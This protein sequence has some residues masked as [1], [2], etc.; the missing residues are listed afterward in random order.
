MEMVEAVALF[1]YSGRTNKELSFKKDQSIFIYK[2]MNHEWWL[3]HIAG[4]SQSGFIPDGYIKLKS[5]RRDSAPVQ[6][7]PQRSIVPN[8]PSSVTFRTLS[9]DRSNASISATSASHIVHRQSSDFSLVDEHRLE[10]AKETEILEVEL[11]INNNEEE[12]EEESSLLIES[13]ANPPVPV[14]RTIYDALSPNNLPKPSIPI[15]SSP[16][17]SVNDQQIIDIDTALR[18]ILSGIQTVEECHAQC[19][20]SMPLSNVQPET[21]APDLVINLPKSNGILTA[22]P[23]KSFDEHSLPISHSTIIIDLAHSSRSNS[24]SPEL[25]R[26][27]K[28][29]PPIMKKPEKTLHLL[30][31]LGLKQTTDSSHGTRTSSLTTRFS[32]PHQQHQAISISRSSKAT[33]V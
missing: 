17:T 31:R 29:P 10:S 1:D 28:I 16:S 30:E 25:T 15:S 3:G 6:H 26:S 5:R 9:S 33:Q 8:P 19:F 11:D 24:S 18:E 20:R 2:K 14:S 27:N 32:F 21:D 4:G 13:H 23:S 7:R 12:G 22:Q